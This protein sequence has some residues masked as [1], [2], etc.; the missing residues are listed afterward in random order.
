MPKG[1]GK[2][3]GDAPAMSALEKA[4]Q[5]ARA[6]VAAAVSELEKHDLESL[7]P[8]GR[9]HSS[10]KLREGE[11]EAMVSILDAVDAQ[12]GVF[13]ALAPHDH[14]QDAKVVETAPARTALARRA[15]LAPLAKDL[16]ALL[17][18]VSDDMISSGEKAKDVTVPAYAIIKANADIAP[19]LRKTAAP[20]IGFYAKAAK[21]L[22]KKTP[23]APKG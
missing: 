23:A 5:K 21:R 18:R 4:V 9:L 15:L 13:A 12:P 14:G 7:T 8:D 2:S 16:D 17:T 3:G 20:A 6:A 1:N 11:D 19:A 22:P 10:G